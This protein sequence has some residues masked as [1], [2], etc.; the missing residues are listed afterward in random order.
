M[1]GMRAALN[2]ELRIMTDEELV[3]HFEHIA[4]CATEMPGTQVERVRA[5][6]LRRLDATSRLDALLAIA[7][8]RDPR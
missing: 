1:N 5:E 4:M 2:E 6:V 3:A 7:K 8:A